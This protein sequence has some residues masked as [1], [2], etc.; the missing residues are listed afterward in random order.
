MKIITFTK[1][2]QISKYLNEEKKDLKYISKKKDVPDWV[3]EYNKE[4]IKRIDDKIK[5][6]RFLCGL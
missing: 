4:E 6:A 3:I 1:I 2:R 5:R